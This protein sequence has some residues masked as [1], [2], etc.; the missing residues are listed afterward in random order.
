MTEKNIFAYN[1]FLSLSNSD[2][3][4]FLCEKC[5][6]PEKESAPFSQQPPLKVEFL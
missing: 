1:F 5:N 3:N 2:F 6:P 4:V